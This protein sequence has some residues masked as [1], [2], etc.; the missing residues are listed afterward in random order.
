MY[1]A[2]LLALTAT[3]AAAASSV[4]DASATNKH[5]ELLRSLTSSLAEVRAL[6]AREYSHETANRKQ[7]ESTIDSYVTVLATLARDAG[8]EPPPA[9]LEAYTAVSNKKTTVKAAA[10]SSPSPSTSTLFKKRKLH[11]EVPECY[12][13]AGEACVPLPTACPEPEPIPPCNCP[14]QAPAPP[15][16]PPPP[17]E[18]PLPFPPSEPPSPPDEPPPAPPFSPPAPSLVTLWVGG[19]VLMSILVPSLLVCMGM[20][21]RFIASHTLMNPLHACLRCL[22]HS[23]APLCRAFPSQTASM[24]A[25]RMD[26]A[27]G[28]K[29]VDDDV[30]IASDSEPDRVEQTVFY[31]VRA[32]R[33]L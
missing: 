33:T 21:K 19:G 5:A 15:F 11:E 23:D 3:A 7:F 25:S 16:D 18:I 6:A 30:Q 9:L 27:D 10:P 29:A 14:P 4:E 17:P 1:V 31:F 12:D 24:W 26:G 2:R 22:R 8:V 28:Y 20:C 13:I 32:L